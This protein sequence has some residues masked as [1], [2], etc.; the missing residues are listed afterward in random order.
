MGVIKKFFRK[1][2][3][4]V[5]GSTQSKGRESTKGVTIPAPSPPP[6]KKKISRTFSRTCRLA[7]HGPVLIFNYEMM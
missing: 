6:K 1:H 2:L 7:K 4:I 3:E 5:D